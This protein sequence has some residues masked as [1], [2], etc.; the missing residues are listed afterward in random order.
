M[1]GSR[2]WAGGRRGDG[3]AEEEDEREE[4]KGLLHRS[5]L[6]EFDTTIDNG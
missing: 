3:G 4:E 6:K 2:G 1:R 5:V